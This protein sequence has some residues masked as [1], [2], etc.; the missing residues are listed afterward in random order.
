MLHLRMLFELNE[1]LVPQYTNTIQIFQ[2]QKSLR[3]R[4]RIQCLECLHPMHKEIS[5]CVKYLGE[6]YQ[7]NTS[8]S[9]FCL[10]I[11]SLNFGNPLLDAAALVPDAAEM[12]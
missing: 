6:K 9:C 10:R 7:K 2:L 4:K 12:P 3:L 1:I 5:D 8:E 11:I